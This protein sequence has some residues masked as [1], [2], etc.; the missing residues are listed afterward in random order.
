MSIQFI[1][2]IGHRPSSEIFETEGP[3][4]NK[5]YIQRFAQAHEQAG[6]D[7]VLVGYW[8]NQPDG[9][10]VTALAGAATKNLNFLLAHRPGFVAPALAARKLATLEHLLNGRLAVHV[11]SGGSDKEQRKDGDY[12]DHDQRYARTDEFIHIVKSIWTADKPFSYVGTH[13]Q[14]EDAESELRPLQAPHIPIYFGGASPAAIEVAGKHA[15]VYAM[16]GEPLQQIKETIANV[17][18]EAA[19][20]GREVRFSIS[21]RPILGKTEEEAWH[22]ADDILAKA[23][24]R[25]ADAGQVHPHKPDSVGAQRL[26]AAAEQGDK[27]DACLWTGISK[28]VGGA[29]NSTAL[30]GTPEQVADAL[31]AYYDLGVDTFLIRGFDPLEDVLEYGRELIPLT[32]QKAASRKKNFVA[33]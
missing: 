30:V 2:M 33:V 16:W 10:L 19:S 26:R 8:S 15:D 3:V 1:G 6:F 7:R 11:I 25:L 32:R 22:K 17:R 21:F 4:F 12:I 20:H 29:Y 13:Y 24:Q 5:E 14:V 18:A 23:T 27:I 28:L 31:L 9:F